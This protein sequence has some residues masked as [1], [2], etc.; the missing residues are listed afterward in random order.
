MVT[1]PTVYTEQQR[2]AIEDAYLD[3]GIRPA[4]RIAD[5]A[6]RGELRCD[7][8]PVAPFRTSESSVRDLARRARKRRAGRLQSKLAE[9]PPRDAVEALRRRLLSLVDHELTRVE[10]EQKRRGS[11]PISG[12]RLRQIAR[13]ARETAALPGLDDPR[14]RAPGAHVPEAGGKLDGATRGGL[15]A[16]VLRAHNNRGIEP[17]NDPDSDHSA[18]MDEAK[19]AVRDGVSTQAPN[20]QLGEEL[21]AFIRAQIAQW[22]D[23]S[24]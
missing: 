21:G 14:P 4:R 24:D 2:T 23:A 9:L 20:R 17:V 8:E 16:A 3:E 11:K 15:A 1:W 5:R 19:D 6:A 10:R 18:A 22:S 13:A 7:G 12:E